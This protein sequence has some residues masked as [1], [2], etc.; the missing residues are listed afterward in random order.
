LLSISGGT[1]TVQSL[2]GQDSLPMTAQTHVYRVASTASTALAVGQRVAIAPDR[3]DPSTATSV[4]IAPPGNVFVR[5]RAF[6]SGTGGFGSGSRGGSFG[7]GGNG[8]GFGSGGNG[9]G[10]GSGGS[11]GGFGRRAGLAGTITALGHGTITVKMQQEGS[12]TIKLTALTGVYRV[13]AATRE[14]L[15]AGSYVSVGTAT[16]DGRQVAADVV[17]ATTPGTMPT[18][19]PAA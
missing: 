11:G 15:K 19:I 1:L 10:F 5:V 17:E 6:S 7:S 14:G 16:V 18:I 8:G 9:G 12:Q 13:V 2:V 4:T 3:N